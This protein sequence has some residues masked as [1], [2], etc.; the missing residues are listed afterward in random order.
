MQHVQPVLRC[1]LEN[2]LFVK[3]EKCEFHTTTV[4][5][6]G[7]IVQQGQL[8]ADLAKILE[9]RS[10]GNLLTVERL[11]WKAALVRLFQ[12]ASLPSRTQL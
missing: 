3:A 7:F 12:L 4:S 5:F 8:S 1:L 10:R 9:H 2:S 11:R 6:L